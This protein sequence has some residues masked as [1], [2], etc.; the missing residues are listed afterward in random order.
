MRY[1]N[2]YQKHQNNGIYSSKPH[3]QICDLTLYPFLIFR[4]IIFRIIQQ[5]DDA[6]KGCLVAIIIPLK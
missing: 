6:Q 4:D 3:P 1:L 5:L 2:Y